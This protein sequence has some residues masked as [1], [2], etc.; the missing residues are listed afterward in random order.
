MSLSKA[1]KIKIFAFSFGIGLLATGTIAITASC[2]NNK[3]SLYWLEKYPYSH[4]WY[5]KDH[6]FNVKFNVNENFSQQM[7][8]RNQ[9]EIYQSM[10][11]DFQTAYGYNLT[12]INQQKIKINFL[13]N[14]ID[15]L[16][17]HQ[18]NNTYNASD[19]LTLN[20]I[21]LNFDLIIYTGLELEHLANVQ[22][23]SFIR[24]VSLYDQLTKLLVRNLDEELDQSIEEIKQQTNKKNDQLIHDSEYVQDFDQRKRFIQEQ[25]N[26]N[27]QTE[28]TTIEHLRNHFYK[29]K[30]IYNKRLKIVQKVLATYNFQR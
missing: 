3:E 11:D 15:Q 24:Y 27:Q 30:A 16:K 19:L 20:H 21:I 5:S 14:Q 18:A 9:L 23:N 2:A 1:K 13:Q 22:K 7:L 8:K 6:H 10:I 4:N 29:I 26:F 17:A 25:R 12:S 28:N